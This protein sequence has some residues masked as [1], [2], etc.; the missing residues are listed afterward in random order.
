MKTA[1]ASG[2]T[3]TYAY[4]GLGER[5]KKTNAAATVHFAHDE[6]GHLLGEYD[7]E[8]EL[9]QETVWF[10]DI[11]VATLRPNGGSGVDVYYVHADHLNTPRR[12]TDPTDSDEIVWRWDSEPYGATAA[13]EDPDDDLTDFVYNLRF[14]G[15]Y[16]DQETG[17]HYNY[18]R[19]YDAATGRYVESDPIG[20]DGGLNTYLY[21]EANSLRYTDAEGL[22][23]GAEALPAP[24]VAE[25]AAA[26]A[27]AAA[28]AGVGV[29]AAAAVASAGMAGYGLGTLLYPGYVE[30]WLSPAIDWMCMDSEEERCRKVKH[31]CIAACSEFGLP[32]KYRDGVSFRRCIRNCMERRGCFN[33]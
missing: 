9:I 25:A 7:E 28:A 11:P 24:G 22:Q 6:A 15:Q 27:R 2:S 10:G 31:E 16:F 32:T 19:D 8:G 3:T 18:F 30:P 1:T 12:V 13:D 26:A 20:L 17:L 5:V 4:N 33:F 21:A 29:G 23:I 14:P